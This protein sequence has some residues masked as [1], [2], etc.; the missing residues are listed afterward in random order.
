MILLVS[1]FL[2][3]GF[4]Y[5]APTDEQI[6]QAANTLGVPYA[7]L[8]AFVQSYQVQTTPSGTISVTA[9]DLIQSYSGNQLQANNRY[10]GKNLQIT[11]QVKAVK[12][13]YSGNY[14]VELGTGDYT[15]CTVR[16]YVKASEMNKI[17]NLQNNQTATFVGN[18]FAGDSNYVDINEAFLVR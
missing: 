9:A 1:I 5:S 8:K 16:V 18:C 3:V 11:G 6:R 2:F 15:W 14:Y 4:V 10:K 12:Q 17:A 13:D 7:D